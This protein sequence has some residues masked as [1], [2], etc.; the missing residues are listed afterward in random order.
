MTQTYRGTRPWDDAPRPSRHNTHRHAMHNQ[1]A[2]TSDAGA[3]CQA[4][5]AEMIPV[6]GIRMRELLKKLQQVDGDITESILRN[7]I[8][9][10]S[11]LEASIYEDDKGV[12][13]KIDK[14]KDWG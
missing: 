12:L 4:L 6:S 14:E 2:K 8:N 3:S 11:V 5:I 13:Y 1:T 10:L 9:H 7:A